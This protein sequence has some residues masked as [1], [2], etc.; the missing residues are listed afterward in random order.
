M[1]R[2]ENRQSDGV[3]YSLMETWIG[4]T[5]EG[6]RLILVSEVVFT[7]SHL[8][9]DRYQVF[10]VDSCAHLYPK[11]KITLHHFLEPE[12]ALSQ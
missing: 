2:V 3:A 6:K 5:S 11:R 4:T 1:F 8:M 10:L 9:M 7:M 12:W